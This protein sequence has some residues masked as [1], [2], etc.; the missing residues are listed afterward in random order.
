MAIDTLPYGLKVADTPLSVQSERTTATEHQR[1]AV[2]NDR[3]E[4]V[5]S[6]IEGVSFT[7]DIP[8]IDHAKLGRPTDKQYERNRASVQSRLKAIG[9]RPAAIIN[10][11]PIPLRSDST[12]D[13]LRKARIR[14][15]NPE[16]EFTAT[17]VAHEHLEPTRMGADSPLMCFD[18]HPL[19]LADEFPRVY[20]GFGGVMVYDFDKSLAV[21]DAWR[22]EINT[23]EWRAHVSEFHGGRTLGSVLDE[24]KEKAITWMRKMLENGN[25]KASL[26]QNVN[27]LTMEKQS[28]RRLHALGDITEL[29]D[30]VEQRRDLTKK[31]T[32]CPKCQKPAEPSVAQC[33]TPG[34]G[35]IVNPRLAYEIS[36]IGEEHEALERLTREEVREMGIS[37]Y[38]AETIDEKSERLKS[39]RRKPLSNAAYGVQK[40]QDEYDAE[41]TRQSATLI[42]EA[43]K[44]AGK[45]SKPPK[46]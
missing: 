42:G 4:R 10:F 23:P 6:V 17:L 1:G 38:V 33:L 21:N 24:C 31:R 20:A 3:I 14:P 5:T 29:P 26:D 44:E 39:G 18:I 2:R 45:P 37:D 12:I 22:K 43:V 40:A 25:N 27:I 15:P 8:A 35:Y 32:P 34:C 28:A 16:E 19:Q 46:E 30:W 9:V 13:V 36:A 11:L 7:A 41:K